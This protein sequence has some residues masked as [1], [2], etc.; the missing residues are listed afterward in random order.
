MTKLC[1]VCFK[2]LHICCLTGC[3][4]ISKHED[5]VPYEKASP[6]HVME[7]TDAED[8][9]PLLVLNSIEQ[10]ELRKASEVQLT[11]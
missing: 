1:A 10:K 5:S 9:K 8:G 4:G 3:W 2:A 11:D 7:G 6:A